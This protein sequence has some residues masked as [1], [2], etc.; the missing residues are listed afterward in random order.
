MSEKVRCLAVRQPWAWALVA[1]AKDIENRSWKTDYRGPIVIQASSAKTLVNSLTKGAGASLPPMAFEY[2]ALIGVVDLIDIVP[3]SEELES[4]PWAW[5]P[6]CWRVGNARRFVEPIPAKGKLN[7]YALEP[8]L[9]ECA[10]AAIAT[11]T[12]VKRDVTAE[13]WIAAM[14]RLD[15]E[16]R[17]TVGL[18]G[19]YLRL[20]D[21]RNALRLAE[22][23]VAQIGDADAYIDRAAAKYYNGDHASALED[24]N[25]AIAISPSSERAPIV[26]GLIQDAMKARDKA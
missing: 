7:L 6:H 4:N 12:V 14:L 10:A 26:R 15:T 17:R 22:R 1:G 18:L 9:A 2:S 24:I 16:E 8:E 20:Q 3:I 25:Q 23:T 13:A 5:G 19:S 21:G 11:A